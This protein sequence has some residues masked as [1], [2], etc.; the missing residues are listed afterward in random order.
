MI[1]TNI[2]IEEYTYCTETARHVARVCMHLKNQV[3]T[4][5]CQ[6][7]LPG[8]I[9]PATRND[10]IIKEATRQMMR[11]PEYRS[12]RETLEFAADIPA[13]PQRLAA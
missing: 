6:L 9:S 7:K 3:V 2:E 13:G 1:V 12:G 10:A 4:L 11:M 5:F 8:G